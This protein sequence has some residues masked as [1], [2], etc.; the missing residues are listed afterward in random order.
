MTFHLFIPFHDYFVL[1]SIRLITLMF[2]FRCQQLQYALQV[3]QSTTD[4]GK[5]KSHKCT[6][7]FKSINITINSETGTF[8]LLLLPTQIFLLLDW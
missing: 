5:Y 8:L 1:V 7:V 4:K 6:R 2:L 3:F